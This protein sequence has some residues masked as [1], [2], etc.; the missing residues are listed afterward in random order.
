MG[1]SNSKTDEIEKKLDPSETKVEETPRDA[2]HC[3]EEI[4]HESVE[5]TPIKTFEAEKESPGAPPKKSHHSTT[6]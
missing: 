2:N 5:V 6:L 4:E 1:C 3:A